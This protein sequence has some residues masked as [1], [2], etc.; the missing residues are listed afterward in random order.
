MQEKLK[1]QLRQFFIENQDHT[2]ADD[3]NLFDSGLL[4]SFGI[5]EF[6]TY[7]ETETGNELDIEEITE[8]NFSTINSIAELLVK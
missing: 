2:P 8:E 1:G 3:E 7:I 6:L 4:D 5:V